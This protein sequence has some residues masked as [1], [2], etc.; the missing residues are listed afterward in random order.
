MH[1]ADE[2]TFLENYRPSEPK[3]LYHRSFTLRASE[4][5]EHYEV[6]SDVIFSL[7]QEVSSYHAV[8]CGYNGHLQDPPLYS[9][10]VNR[11]SLRLAR[12]PRWP[13][14]V[15]VYTWHSVMDRLGYTR[16]YC[17]FDEK[18]HPYGAARSYWTLV[19]PDEHRLV[20]PETLFIH[21]SKENP[22]MLPKGIFSVPPVRLRPRFADFTAAVK[23]SRTIG[24]SDIDSNNHL[25]N[26]RYIALCRD[27]ADLLKPQGSLK[28]IDINYVAEMFKG[29]TAEVLAVPYTEKNKAEEEE[30]LQLIALCCP[31]PKGDRFRA[32]LGFGE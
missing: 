11:M 1:F 21:Q 29:E 3:A 20:K 13:E 25:N 7:L 30:D 28:R 8:N 24:A 18:G 14:T 16:D 23:T 6:H 9:W 2:Q 5:D 17:L 4:C 10:I 26:T 12:V 27:T 31:G 32:V 19:T 22:Y 15:K